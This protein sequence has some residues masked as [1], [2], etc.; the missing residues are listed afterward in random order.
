MLWHTKGRYI[1]AIDPGMGKSRIAAAAVAVFLTVLYPKDTKKIHVIFPNP[2]LC[3]R[4]RDVFQGLWTIFNSSDRVVYHSGHCGL[5]FDCDKDDWFIYDE[6]DHMIFRD[7]DNFHRFTGGHPCFCL[8]ATPGGSSEQAQEQKVLESLKLHRVT[9]TTAV[10]PALPISVLHQPL[11]PFVQGALRSSA[12]IVWCNPDDAD[13]LR[14]AF[15]RNAV[16]DDQ[17]IAEDRNWLEELDCIHK[18]ADNDM[19]ILLI[20]TDP[21]LMRAVDYRAKNHG[22]ALVVARPFNCAREAQQGAGRVGR[23][24]DPCRRLRMQNVELIDEE[25]SDLYRG[26]LMAFCSKLLPPI[27]PLAKN[28]RATVG[29]APRKPKPLAENQKTLQ[30]PRL[31]KRDAQQQKAYQG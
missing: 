12:V 26:R 7:P 24:E 19:F 27:K 2:Y 4:D 30:F 15:P 3:N 14:A 6:A 22:I 17:I 28:S 31:G 9:D 5:A 16:K 29:C 25:Q 1:C 8:T 11:V 20:V 13:N 23:N 10:S 21:Q 18:G